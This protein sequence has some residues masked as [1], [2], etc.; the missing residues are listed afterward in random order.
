MIQRNGHGV[1]GKTERVARKEENAE[2]LKAD[3]LERKELFWLPLSVGRRGLQ[4]PNKEGGVV[5]ASWTNSL[6][7]RP[8]Q[9]NHGERTFQC[10]V[11]TDLIL[12][13]YL[14]KD[15]ESV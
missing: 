9:G 12:N 15:S 8:D 2:F 6:S 1:G 11:C 14:R 10:M 3:K 5:R 13:G 4:N 7:G